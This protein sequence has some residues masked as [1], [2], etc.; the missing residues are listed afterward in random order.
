MGF[1]EV[2][3]FSAYDAGAQSRQDEI[4]ELKQ[5]ITILEIDVHIRDK[6]INE[7]LS[8]IEPSDDLTHTAYRKICKIL[9]GNTK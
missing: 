5:R 9:K 6:M 8:Y 1:D 7:A 3:Y 4:N 2:N